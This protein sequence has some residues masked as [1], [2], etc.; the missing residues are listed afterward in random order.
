MSNHDKI[1]FSKEEYNKLVQIVNDNL[2][3]KDDE[4]KYIAT[5]LKD[6]FDNYVHLY[7]KETKGKLEEG[8]IYLAYTNELKWLVQECLY[9]IKKKAKK[10]YYEELKIKENKKAEYSIMLMDGTLNSHLK[11]IQ[12]TA[13]ERGEKII[14]QLK[15]KSNLTEDMKNAD[16]LYWM[17]MM[18]NFK[19]QAEEIVFNELIYV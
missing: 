2:K 16:M 10:D 12:E 6:K 11:E 19:N 7:E 15:E 4:I 9:L 13:T 17:G 3:C 8:V 18:N 1:Y 5:R 14:K